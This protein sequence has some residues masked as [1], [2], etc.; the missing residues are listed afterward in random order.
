LQGFAKDHVDIELLKLK[1]Y[2]VVSANFSDKDVLRDGFLDRVSQVFGCMSEF[3]GMLN[4]VCMPDDNSSDSEEDSEDGE[5][6]QSEDQDDGQEE[7]QD[8]GQEEE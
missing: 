5:E 6:Q 1:S 4:D 2:R 8:E 7:D 3:I